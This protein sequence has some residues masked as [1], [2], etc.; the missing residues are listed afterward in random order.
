MSVQF[1]HSTKR[2]YGFDT[3]ALFSLE[4]IFALK[5]DI[6]S[7]RYSIVSFFEDGTQRFNYRFSTNQMT[8]LSLAV[9]TSQ[10]VD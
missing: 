3:H 7:C 10:A 5:I 8:A 2:I 1:G 6:W 4:N 9:E